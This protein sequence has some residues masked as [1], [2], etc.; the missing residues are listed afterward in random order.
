M[1]KYL[2]AV[3]IIVVIV[4]IYVVTY[5]LNENTDRPEGCEDLECNGCNAKDCSHRDL[6]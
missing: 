3:G 1:A 4:I 6:S 5:V 2:I